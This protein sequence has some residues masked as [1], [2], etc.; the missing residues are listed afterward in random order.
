[1]PI[2]AVALVHPPDPESLMSALTRW[3][4]PVAALAMP[5]V[6]WLTQSGTFGGDVGA[7]SNRFRTLVVPAG[8]AFGIWGLIFLLD[9]LFAGWQAAPSRADERSLD[10]VRPWAIAGVGLTAAWMPVFVQQWYTGAVVVIWGSLVAM[11][12]AAVVAARAAPGSAAA[13]PVVRVPLALHAGW[14]SLAAFVNTAQWALA[15]GWTSEATQWPLSIGLWAG[16][17]VLLLAVQRALASSGPAL[18]AYSGAAAWGLV[19]VVIQQRG[20]ALDGAAA[21]AMVA[22]GLLLALGLHGAW[23][24]RRAQV[25]HPEPGGVDSISRAP[26]RR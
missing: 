4:L 8:Y 3:A 2:A 26:V 11:L 24:L 23:L 7:E 20:S 6:S 17:A 9:L 13:S 19:G 18:L 21:S 22:A 10:A 12:W 1:M 14:L 15:L 16:A 25:G 5:L